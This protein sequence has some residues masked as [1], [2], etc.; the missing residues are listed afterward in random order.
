MKYCLAIIK[1]YLNDFRTTITFY[2]LQNKELMH[3]R[4]ID[5]V[6]VLLLE[7]L[8]LILVLDG[9]QPYGCL[10]TLPQRNTYFLYLYKPNMCAPPLLTNNCWYITKKVL[11]FM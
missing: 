1:P 3:T 6:W 7:S 10:S 11:Y 2:T 9:I 5:C 8:V 4:V